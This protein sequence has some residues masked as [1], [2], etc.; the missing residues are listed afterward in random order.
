MPYVFAE[1]VTSSAWHAEA[2]AWIAAHLDGT[3]TGITQLRVRPWS[4]N[5]VVESSTGRH[6]F[7]ALPHE[8]R[9]EA[10]VLALLAEVAPEHV[11][12]PVA[13]DAERGW[14]LDRDR[15]ST[16]RDERAATTADWQRLVVEVARLQQQA[17]R[18]GDALL[19]AGLPDARPDRTVGLFDRFLTVFAELDESHPCHLDGGALASLHDRRPA[20]VEASARLVDSP[21]PSTLQHGDVHTGNVFVAPDRLRLF[22]FG[23]A[24][25]AHAFEVLAVPRGVID[26]EEEGAVSWDAVLAA[27]CHAWDLTPDQAADDLA[28][29]WLTQPVHR[30]LTWWRAL[31]GASAEQWREWGDTPVHHL[32]RVLADG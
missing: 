18:H 17:A 23:D 25:W 29:A 1:E 28:A 9:Y 20:I 7:K 4:T 15:G 19:T 27:Y 21:V 5:L 24:Q 14:I 16:W 31:A 12:A 11:A 22:D 3:V 6:W 13:I 30:C 26:A 8:L 32:R 10:P 2:E